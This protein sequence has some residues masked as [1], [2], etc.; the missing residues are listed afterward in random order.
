MID[1]VIEKINMRV[2]NKEIKEYVLARYNL[3]IRK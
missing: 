2:K 1:G 3:I